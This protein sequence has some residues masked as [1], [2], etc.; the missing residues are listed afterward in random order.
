IQSAATGKPDPLFT[1]A[2][3]DRLRIITDI[4]EG[5]AGWLKVGQPAGFE[6]DAARGQQF[7]GKVTRFADALDP[8]TRTMRTEVELDAPVAGLRPG[9][10]GSVTITLVDAPNAL[11][12]PTSALL[13]GP[14]KPAVMIVEGGRARRH[15]IELGF[16]D[17][18]RV[19]ITGGL[20]GSEEILAD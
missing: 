5:D 19:Q 3:V 12:L 14:G 2:R 6:A 13:A 10:F 20:T 18:I 17:G 16:N 9:M 11:V 7:A 8:A 1:V 15:E 4:R